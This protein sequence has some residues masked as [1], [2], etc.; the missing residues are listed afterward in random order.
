MRSISYNK[1]KRIAAFTVCMILVLSNF[2]TVFADGTL[3]NSRTVKAG[4]FAFDGYHMKDEEGRLT[5]YGIEF[6]NLVSEH[7]RLNFQYT[8]YDRAWGEMLDMLE[9]GEIDVVTSA[10]RTP[11]REER[12][13]FSLPIGRNN[14]VLSIRFDNIQLHRGDYKTY[15]GITVGQ[16]EGSSQNQSLVEF[17]EEN[18]FSYQVKLYSD[19]E[20]LA[21]A[22]QNG[23]V[24]AILSSDLRKAENEKTLDI[25]EEDYFYAIVRKDDT[26]LI[27][28]I[29][30]AI[31]QM[32]INEGDWKN[33]LLYKYYGPVYS[34][35]L[36]FTEREAE[37][38]R[39]VRAGEKAIT[40]TALG[41]RAPYS[42]AEDGELKGILPDYFAAVMELADLPYEVVVPKDKDDYYALAD[43]NG[44]N[45]VIDR[46]SFDDTIED[47]VYRGFNTD[48]Y[49]TVGMARV[50]RQD[51]SGDVK[52][53]AVSD[54][55]GKDIIEPEFLEGYTVQNYP[56]GEEAMQ[57]VLSRKADV[58]YVYTYTAQLFVNHDSTN[59]LYYSM[60]NGMRTTF[61]MYVSEKTDHELITILN[62]CISQVSG[63]TLN[64]LA[65]KYTSYTISDMSLL[66]YM[67]ANPIMVLV[68]VFVFAL[69][70][71]VIIALYLR[72][73]WNKKLLRATEQS[74][75]KMGE[76]LAIV[77]ALSRDYTNVYAINEE[78]STARIIKLEGYVTEG[79]KKGSTEEHNYAPILEQYIRSRVH[80]EDRQDL[81]LALSL[82]MVKAGLAAD[83]EYKGS[84]RI[85]D[86]GE[87]HHFQYTYLRISD[88]NYGHG[89]FILAGFRN[90]DEVI[91]EE[92]EQKNVLAEALAQA[93]Y[94]NNAKTTF[95]NNMSHDIR[96]P[97]NAIIGF[98]SLAVTHI[99]NK[100]QIRD[101]LSKIM[102]SG[103][104]L[105]SLIN[106]VLDMSRIESGKV[107]IEEKETSL[108]EIMHD[109]KT[110]VQSD[111]K[112]KQLEF[113]IDTLD[114]A[115]ETII[116]DKLRLNQVLLNILSN[117]MK[118][119]KPG[120]MVS[121][122]VIQT[123]EAFEGCASYEFK[124]KDTG[125]GMSREFLKHVFEPFE[126]EQTSTVSGI[127]GTGLGL[128]IT[129]NIVD[130]M[131]GEI[132]VES[133]EGKGSEFTVNFR[134]RVA[135]GSPESQRVEQLADLRALVVDDDVNTCVSV[136]KMLSAIGMRPDW[137]TLGNEAVI[138][139]E[140]AIEQNEPYSA[141]IIDWLMP[142][143]NGIEL[144]RRIRR[145]IGDMTP[146]I[147]LTA[148]DWTDIEE[149]ARE[150]GVTAFCS[151]PLFLSE[152]R[153]A[154]AAPYTDKESA[155]ESDTS[156]SEPRFDG[157]RILLVEDNE[158]NQEI[159]QT[160]LEAA[161]FIIDT[162]DDGSVAVE[163]M[164]EKPADT[165][166]VILMDVQMP[167]MN[168]YQATRAIRALDDPVKA[169]IPIVAMTAN[170]FEEDRKEAMDSG[171]NGY[172]PKPINIEQLMSTLEEILR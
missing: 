91:R 129:K 134:F 57:A 139:T 100:E 131:G 44:V 30:Y 117:A 128:A 152:L 169:A 107:K 31:E 14:T 64:Q 156:E 165:Y 59:S 13:A 93:Q 98:T 120:G 168:G 43:T 105:L 75:R 102:T 26:E 38:I 69:I 92:Q 37:Y 45:V 150:A 108:P 158:L 95:L 28:E 143:M 54:S 151:K 68:Y 19:S 167:I 130:M 157:V 50:I 104:H 96:T 99:D 126:R 149:E 112:A 62:K 90:I 170:A 110:I 29:N 125:I 17:A 121:V 162:A 33:V 83:G 111:V 35:A 97:M 89:G 73:R 153:S 20:A 109:L 81:S 16:L 103:N 10:R 159:A 141:Y 77:E 6:L 22:L 8:G 136:S 48:S 3:S 122:R 133:E 116:C 74:N 65:S 39:Q 137:T 163:M 47:A 84:Y 79:L 63:D 160:I 80:P 32:D 166:N 70:V 148:Y 34:S 36:S 15:N 113:Y 71:C 21:A 146:I 27:N 132:T 12:F 171:M 9:N 76:Q 161:G 138:R 154:L 118:Y 11:D 4:I 7:S 82:D 5:G 41:N 56:T 147:I 86:N 23:D 94:A 67:R 145:V 87:V 123:A 53:V 78:R 88:N 51:F 66:Q 119:T 25:I 106:D 55:Q 124:V 46:I 172:V 85:S 127:Q 142:D 52:V 49:V 18:G 42:Y 72:G 58:A 61:R 140:F 115:N 164:K 144:V 60:M 155:A 1:L 24:D 114:V 135:E 40:V 101:Y 2:I